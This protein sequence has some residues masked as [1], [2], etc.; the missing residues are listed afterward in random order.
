MAHGIDKHKNDPYP[1]PR[2]PVDSDP[3]LILTI[4]YTHGALMALLLEEKYGNF[5]VQ[6]V[7]HRTDLGKGERP[8]SDQIYEGLSEAL[9]EV[10]VSPLERDKF[11]KL[12][13]IDQLVPL[14]EAGDDWLLYHVLNRE[15]DALH[16][17]PSASLLEV[18]AIE[19]LVAASMGVAQDCRDRIAFPNRELYISYVI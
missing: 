17:R 2:E 13:Y 8:Y 18:S 1:D 6:R 16:F 15:R 14:G 4:Q 3:Q 10:T 11:R 19:P 7:L 9:L 12:E 5:R